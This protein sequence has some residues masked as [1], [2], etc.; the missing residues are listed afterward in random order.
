MKALVLVEYN[1]LVYKEVPIPAP[2]P[3]EVLIAV[4]AAGICGSDVH[5]MDGS[6]GRRI[7]PLIMG[8]EAAGFI[9]SVGD[10]VLD[11]KPGDRV[12]FDSTIYRLDDWFTRKGFYNLSDNRMVLGVSCAEFKKDGAFAEF[13]TVP[14]HI[15]YKLPDNVSFEHAA[16]VEPIAV[17]L[18]ALNLTDI[19][20]ND[21]VVVGGAGMIALFVIQLLKLSG[22]GKIIAF[23]IDQS[24][25]DLAVNLGAT[26]VFNA[27]KDNVSEEVKKLT[28]GRGA[29]IGIEVVGISQVLKTVIESV[30]KGGQITLVGNLAP[31][32]NLP[33]QQV[34]TRQLRLQGSCAIAGEYEQAIDLISNGKVQ[35][36]PLLSIVAPLKEGA[37]WF[38]RLHNREKG[39]LKVVLK[40]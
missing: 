9:H 33:L 24:R 1:K 23:D 29:D 2:A 36:D 32:V 39:L 13:V 26:H 7:P 21:T 20:L 28:C 14:S 5:G 16:M 34:V 15:L 18:H 38:S 10:K 17:A 12:T 25:L 4:K 40:P 30:R 11:W 3:D 19:S 37:A 35:I 8:H 27:E 31:E 22:C 6:T